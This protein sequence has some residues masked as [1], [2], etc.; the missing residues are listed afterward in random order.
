MVRRLRIKKSATVC[1]I[2]VFIDL[3]LIH[4]FS[5]SMLADINLF[6][7]HVH[8]HKLRSSGDISSALSYYVNWII[9][10]Q[11]P[12]RYL[13]LFASGRPFRKKK[14]CFHLI[15]ELRPKFSRILLLCSCLIFDVAEINRIIKALDIF[16][17]NFLSFC[18]QY[19]HNYASLILFLIP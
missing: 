19:P 1:V 9:I 3:R 5:V 11:I 12:R 13:R 14:L 16:N 2:T 10:I 4:A 6:L 8:L 17:A 18:V 7:R 15:P